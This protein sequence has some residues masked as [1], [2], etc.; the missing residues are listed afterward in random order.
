ME[1][2]LHNLITELKKRN[3]DKVIIEKENWE[4]INALYKENC[5]IKS[6]CGIEI[7]TKIS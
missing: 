7:I 6:F 1:I 2:T 4:F 3:I 5:D